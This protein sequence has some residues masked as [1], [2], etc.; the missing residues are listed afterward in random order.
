MM[1]FAKGVSV[2][3]YVFDEQGNET[4][5]DYKKMLSIVQNSGYG[6]YLGVEYEGERLTEDQGIKATI[7]LINKC[8]K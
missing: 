1:P 6:S 7:E 5:I 3:S 2:K 8:Y 4:K